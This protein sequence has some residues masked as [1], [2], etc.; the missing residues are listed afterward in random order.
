MIKNVGIIGA[1]TMGSGIAQVA[2]T[3]GC[4]VKIYDTKTDA[5]E[6]AKT[7]LNKILDRLVEKGKINSEEKK[8]I[9]SNIKY[10]SS[11]KELKKSDLTIEAIVENLDI[12]KK[13]IFNPRKICGRRLHYC[14]KYFVIIHCFHRFLVAKTRTLHR[15]PLFQSRAVDAIGRG[16]SSNPNFRRN[17]ENFRGNN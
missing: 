8:R 6:K 2:A 17:L 5:L 3:A 10:V 9:Q 15:H 13:C 7:D 12:K 1:G 4:S 16:Y 11:L 14:F